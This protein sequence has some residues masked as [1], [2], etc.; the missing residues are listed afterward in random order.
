[1]ADEP[2]EDQHSTEQVQQVN[3]LYAGG[4][5]LEKGQEGFVGTF[6]NQEAFFE[7]L[8]AHGGRV[9]VADDTGL[10]EEMHEEYHA[11]QD[12]RIFNI[13]TT[14]HGELQTDLITEWE[15]AAEPTYVR[16]YPGQHGGASLKADGARTRQPIPLSTLMAHPY[17]NR[18]KLMRVEVL[19]LRLWTGPSF[20]VLNG[21]LRNA[22]YKRGKKNCL[23]DLRALKFDDLDHGGKGF[24]TLEEL[25]HGLASVIKTHGDHEATKRFKALVES[26]PRFNHRFSDRQRIQKQEFNDFLRMETGCGKR[27]WGACKNCMLCHAR[28]NNQDCFQCNNKDVHECPSKDFF[29]C[30]HK[31]TSCFKCAP[32][33]DSFANTI[34]VINSAIAKLTKVTNSAKAKLLYRGIHGM[35]Y[36]GD[37]LEIGSS[38]VEFGF[39]S[40][41]PDKHVALEYSRAL[42]CRGRDCEAF[43]HDKGICDQ[44][45]PTVLEV[46]TG[47]LD[48]GA[49]LKW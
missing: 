47:K 39:S 24:I 2:A 26:G 48:C 31:M 41:S 45:K 8:E 16:L 40:C 34:A 23:P 20:V 25:T 4:K 43:A 12:P 38:F 21:A 49:E 17:V 18:A 30:R 35:S 19:A 37:L 44:H 29:R 27:D 6:G 28:C 9:V 10:F 11:C 36:P 46:S 33:C 5:T 3:R 7:G 32:G 22:H 14:N 1:M 42:K 13:T 15:F